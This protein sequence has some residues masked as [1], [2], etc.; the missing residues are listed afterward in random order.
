MR[1][2]V[3]EAFSSWSLG[4][5]IVVYGPYHFLDVG[6]VVLEMQPDIVV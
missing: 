6:R 5:A 1:I 4:I 3:F 2:R